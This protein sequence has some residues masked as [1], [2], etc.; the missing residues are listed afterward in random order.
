MAL[1]SGILL[2][3]CGGNVTPLSSGIVIPEGLD[4]VVDLTD[5]AR[6]NLS[7]DRTVSIFSVSN[8]FSSNNIGDLTASIIPA[9]QFAPNQYGLIVDKNLTATRPLLIQVQDLN[10]GINF[11][12]V[13]FDGDSVAQPGIVSTLAWD[14]IKYYPN[15]VVNNFSSADFKGLKSLIQTRVNQVLAE[16]EQF[17]LATLPIITSTHFLENSLRYNINFLTQAAQFGIR[18]QYD[19]P[20]LP[21]GLGSCS[22]DPLVLCSVVCTQ[23]PEGCGNDLGVSEVQPYYYAD[24]TYIVLPNGT[25]QFAVPFN[26]TNT[27]PILTPGATRPDPGLG[28]PI[29]EGQ[30][31]SIVASI[32]DED[33]DFIDRW[34]HVEYTP[35]KLPATATLV[36]PE[37]TPATFDLNLGAPSNAD[38][39]TSNVI[40]YNEALDTSIYN[41]TLGMT[42]SVGCPDCD[43]AYQTIYYKFTDGGVNE[44]ALWNFKYQDVNRPPQ[45]IR[46]PTGG[47]NDSTYDA[48]LNKPSYCESPLNP[49]TNTN[50][51]PWSCVFRTS[52]PDLNDDPNAAADQFYY[53]ASGL[54]PSIELYAADFNLL[55]FT[56]NLQSPGPAPLAA[57]MINNGGPSI[58]LGGLSGG[59]LSPAFGSGNPIR[60]FWNDNVNNT[61]NGFYSN[62]IWPATDPTNSFVNGHSPYEPATP[63]V[64]GM[65]T[66]AGCN[67]VGGTANLK[68]GL[69]IF[70][71]TINNSVN[72][73]AQ[74]KSSQNLSYSIVAYDRKQNGFSVSDSISRV[75]NFT[76]ITARF[77]A[78]DSLVRPGPSPIGP[79]GVTPINIGISPESDIGVGTV[80]DKHIHTVSDIYLDEIYNL[81]LSTGMISSGTETT[82]LQ[83]LGFIYSTA[84]NYRSAF[85]VNGFNLSRFITQPRN[86]SG[87]LTAAGLSTPPAPNPTLVYNSIAKDGNFFVAPVE[88]DSTACSTLPTTSTNIGQANSTSVNGTQPMGWMF[89]IDAIDT[90]NIGLNPTEAFD[91]VYVAYGD[92]YSALPSLQ[93]LNPI[94]VASP[95]PSPWQ[96]TPN[97]D[98]YFCSLPSPENDANTGN[99]PIYTVA[100]DP[101]GMAA[102]CTTLSSTPPSQLQPVP[103]YYNTSKGYKKLVYHRLVLLWKPKDQLLAYPNPGILNAFISG[104]VLYGD[105]FSSVHSSTG[106]DT[107]ALNVLNGV[108]GNDAQGNPKVFT[109]YGCLQDASTIWAHIQSTQNPAP[110][111]CP[112]SAPAV[113]TVGWNPNPDPQNLSNGLPLAMNL[114]A[115]AVQNQELDFY[116]RRQEFKPC[117]ETVVAQTNQINGGLYNLVANQSVG[118]NLV[119]Q[120]LS[121]STYQAAPIGPSVEALIAVQDQNARGWQ[122]LFNGGTLKRNPILPYY[123]L[124]GGIQVDVSI[125]GTRKVNQPEFLRWMPFLST[126]DNLDPEPI[127]WSDF[128]DLTSTAN[129]T[130][131]PN[132]TPRTRLTS[133]NQTAAVCF[134]ANFA[135]PNNPLSTAA[136]SQYRTILEIHNKKNVAVNINPDPNRPT[137]TVT[138]WN[139]VQ[140]KLQRGLYDANGGTSPLNSQNTTYTFPLPSPSGVT[141]NLF[142]TT[143]ANDFPAGHSVECFPPSIV[144]NGIHIYPEQSDVYV[145]LSCDLPKGASWSDDFITATVVYAIDP[146]TDYGFPDPTTQGAAFY[147]YPL[148]SFNWLPEFYQATTTTAASNFITSPYAAT[149]AS[150]Y[151]NFPFDGVNDLAFTAVPI[152]TFQYD[153]YNTLT[154]TGKPYGNQGGTFYVYDPYNTNQT[155]NPTGIVSST[156]LTIP[157][158]IAGSPSPSPFPVTINNFKNSFAVSALTSPSPGVAEGYL[159]PLCTNCGPLVGTTPAPLTVGAPS[160]A[161]AFE[162][163]DWNDKPTTFSLGNGGTNP[164]PSPT[165][166]PYLCTSTFPDP[167]STTTQYCY[168]NVGT[169]NDISV[170]YRSPSTGAADIQIDIPISTSD[171][172][173]TLLSQKAELDPFDVHIF[174]MN[175]A[176]GVNSW[177]KNTNFPSPTPP[178][179]TLY[180]VSTAQDCNDVPTGY[181]GNLNVSSVGSGV[182]TGLFE[183][184]KFFPYIGSRSLYQIF[185]LYRQCD[186]HWTPRTL[187]YGKTYTFNLSV[188]DNPALNNGG[189]TV[190]T[191]GRFP[192]TV[193]VGISSDV[194]PAPTPLGHTVSN[195][196]TI[197]M[198]EPNID[199]TFISS[200]ANTPCYFINQKSNSACTSP[201]PT[202][203]LLSSASLPFLSNYPSPLPSPAVPCTTASGSCSEYL[204]SSSPITFQQGITTTFNVSATIQRNTQNFDT[205]SITQPGF[206]RVFYNNTSLPPVDLQFSSFVSPT[207][208]STDPSR[209]T[210]QTLV[211]NASDSDTSSNVHGEITTQFS[212]TPN[213]VAAYNLSTVNGF[214]IP[215]DVS[216]LSLDPTNSN[217]SLSQ[218]FVT[219]AT[220]SRIWIWGKLS[221]VNSIELVKEAAYGTG[222]N[223][224]NLNGYTF[225]LTAGLPSSAEIIVQKATNLAARFHG[226]LDY[227]QTANQ[228]RP[229]LNASPDPLSFVSLS[230]NFNCPV[231]V[232]TPA[233]TPVPNTTIPGSHTAG[234]FIVPPTTAFVGPY[235]EIYPLTFCP[236][237]TEVGNSYDYTLTL[238]DP[239]DSSMGQAIDPNASCNPA[240][241][242]LLGAPNISGPYDACRSQNPGSH[243]Y[244]FHVNI[245][246]APTFTIPAPSPQQTTYAYVQQPFSYPTAMNVTLP[247]EIRQLFFIGL[248]NSTANA[249][250]TP[251]RAATNETPGQEAFF[252]NEKY[253]LKWNQA[254]YLGT[255]PNAPVT[256]TTLTLYGVTGTWNAS[257]PLATGQY[258]HSTAALADAANATGFSGHKDIIRF[259]ESANGGAGRVEHCYLSSS[260][261]FA[262]SSTTKLNVEITSQGPSTIP[263]ILSSTSLTRTYQMPN[264]PNASVQK[265]QQFNEFFDRCLDCTANPGSGGLASFSG[266]TGH[267]FSFT[268]NGSTITKEYNYAVPS[269]SPYIQT[270]LMPNN[271]AT[272]PFNGMHFSAEKGETLTFSATLSSFS[273]SAPYPIYHWYANGCL[274]NSGIAQSTTISATY[275]V[276]KT[277]DGRLDDC[278]AKYSEPEPG[279]GQ[280]GTLLIRLTVGY[281]TENYSMTAGNAPNNAGTYFS[282]LVDGSPVGFL[283]SG[284]ILNTNPILNTAPGAAPNLQT[285]IVL[286]GSDYNGTKNSTFAIPVSLSSSFGPQTAA[287]STNE[288]LAYTDMGTSN[289]WI[290]IKNIDTHGDINNSYPEFYTINSSVTPVTPFSSP[291]S[292]VLKCSA[293]SSSSADW[294][295]INEDTAFS[296]TLGI[297][298]FQGSVTSYSNVKNY[299]CY[300]KQALSIKSTV[301]A[302]ATGTTPPSGSLATGYLLFSKFKAQKNTM[303]VFNIGTT[304]NTPWFLLDETSGASIFYTDADKTPYSGPSNNYVL[305]TDSTSRYIY[306]TENTNLGFTPNPADLYSGNTAY[307]SPNSTRLPQVGNYLNNIV[308]KIINAGVDNNGVA[309]AIFLVGASAQTGNTSG[310]ILIQPLTI[311]TGTGLLSPATANPTPI[312][313]SIA[314]DCQIDGQSI[315]GTPIDAVYNPK[316]DSTIVLISPDQTKAIGGRLISIDN[317]TTSPTC[318]NIYSNGAI[319]VLPNPSTDNV[320]TQNPNMSKLVLDP[321]RQMV[322]GIINNGTPPSANDSLFTLDALTEIVNSQSISSGVHADQIVLDSNYNAVYIFDNTRATATSQY[323]TLYRVW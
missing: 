111:F 56:N 80:G 198:F 50:D 99:T 203:S 103:V 115:P 261:A 227:T 176:S 177:T 259:N 308:R 66:T 190:P 147:S 8:N 39:Y 260:D 53:S 75:I 107:R 315:D 38:Q 32:L 181:P 196:I 206:V 318:R 22:T 137:Q 72:V 219:P 117:V 301:A 229:T 129:P 161:G 94:D 153:Q 31:F 180:R 45:F 118:T 17:S 279:A 160:Y 18:Y 211:A 189:S 319:A 205:L 193:E 130:P 285:P 297:D 322:Y 140:Q 69:G 92:S 288:F 25:K 200:T 49:V 323:P 164:T 212:W 34:M 290:H 217:S 192:G 264:A 188:N 244:T 216:N 178:S 269:N 248:D 299:S 71:V 240:S 78:F 2:S 293:S 67:P 144:L 135:A 105:A 182:S 210:S 273:N 306:T 296:D 278:T 124:N 106:R 241:K 128:Q 41:G 174:T 13:L 239:G 150:T 320:N 171:N 257:E 232:A 30:S 95:S 168:Q 289:T 247:Q 157:V 317:T 237:L 119:T 202:P 44:V 83:N 251:I 242:A 65:M 133:M 253:L 122:N 156:A 283:W 82:D 84:A 89:E 23:I 70:Q 37:P 162:V 228:F 252:V 292:M 85:S 184:T 1:L 96:N 258:C 54:D 186:V 236:P 225:N 52:D 281:G 88:F 60:A 87:P 250:L 167:A 298:Y 81:A 3:S 136:F 256:S 142:D 300:S 27:L 98:F 73:A 46:N 132:L 173:Y 11:T 305:F 213:D 145:A 108:C 79:D 20:L 116:A 43:T 275:T 234:P 303:A 183:K 97:G 221:T 154:N 14:L 114:C 311:N 48:Y 141:F 194:A 266:A 158:Q 16:S 304:T 201:V 26:N 112:T 120:P 125:M 204:Q 4:L 77:V 131:T 9:N 102:D 267:T 163:V 280:L 61:G 222:A 58:F 224:Q 101:H 185:Q 314:N 245:T 166:A 126:C 10:L 197:K 5:A 233:L 15:S 91:N 55:H 254:R 243:S 149:I 230:T 187:D 36:I 284:S 42:P 93:I 12:D 28:I 152:N 291:S 57:P 310:F 33:G 231:A 148:I 277:A 7:A 155:T 24:N 175:D 265:N 208:L 139:G 59:F 40:H 271:L 294:F 214:L 169:T 123:A 90:S 209:L 263:P 21:Q 100:T 312:S 159:S 307:S 63:L 238:T 287:G 255:D 286:T 226:T 143:F 151:N 295:G 134:G 62:R 191:G 223:P 282:S 179:P 218:F 64:N 165:A 270:G 6:F 35:R 235:E 321:T 104:L 109:R 313:V 272:T 146:I 207:A 249:N 110:Q 172:G 170:Y 19:Q 276:P 215:V 68:C 195:T 47:I 86:V 274:F 51:N 268:V 199:P 246:G 121:Q 220:K 138:N 29:G 127:V 302:S 309:T 113:G 74:Q 316:T 76:P 262:Y